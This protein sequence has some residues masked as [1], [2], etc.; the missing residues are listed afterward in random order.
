MKIFRYKKIEKKQIQ[1]PPEILAVRLLQRANISRQEKNILTGINYEIK[2]TIY[3]EAKKMLKRY[4]CCKGAIS[5]GS[6][7]T[8]ESKYKFNTTEY[9]RVQGSGHLPIGGEIGRPWRFEWNTGRYAGAR[10]YQKIKSEPAV[11]QTGIKKKI[12][13]TGRDGEVLK[14]KSCGSFRHLL[15]DCPDSW[16]NMGMKV[17]EENTE[18]SQ[19]HSDP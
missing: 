14:C 10:K 4:G 16:E 3:E 9:F 12:N 5:W 15:D 11:N 19:R 18:K 2:A 17:D 13:P 7:F 8:G 1:L 6:S